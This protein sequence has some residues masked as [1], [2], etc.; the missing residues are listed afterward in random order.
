M[1]EKARKLTNAIKSCNVLF[2]SRTTVALLFNED[3][4]TINALHGS[5]NDYEEF[6]IKI[7]ALAG[8]FEVNLDPLRTLIRGKVEENWKSIKLIEVWLLENHIAFDSNIFETWRKIIGI[9]NAS[10][11]YHHTDARIVEIF[12]YFGQGFPPQFSMLYESILDKLLT[13]IDS[14]QLALNAIL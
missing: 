1:S 13:S 6:A 11:P 9:R 4:Q 2:C 5:C 8:L 12:Q 7:G 14:F 3:I 10:F